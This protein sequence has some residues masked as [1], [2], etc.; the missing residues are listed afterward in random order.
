MRMGRLQQI[1]VYGV[2]ATVALSGLFWFIAHD[3]FD[4]EPNE[5]LRFLL[6][7]HG[8]SAYMLLL[9]LG[10]LLPIHVR[11]GLRRSK[12]VGTGLSVTLALTTLLITAL[13]L[14]YGS[15]ETR[16][17]ARWIHIVVGLL[18]F[19]LFST[20]VVLG[21]KLRRA[22]KPLDLAAPSYRRFLLVRRA[23]RQPVR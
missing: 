1:A 10:S 18:S 21:W 14:Y 5:V 15:E 23:T 6:V 12:N 19:A 2:L 9:V 20:H 8:S 17:P 13:L 22:V 16:L 4:S 7:A 3:L 11:S